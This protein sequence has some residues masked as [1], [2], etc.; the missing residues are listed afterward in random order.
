M[1][2]RVCL[3]VSMM[4]I[5]MPAMA[6]S[7]TAFDGTYAGVSNTAAGGGTQCIP[8][9]PVPRPL[10]IKNGAV[11]WASG[12]T[13]DIIFQG[14]VTAQ[15]ALTAKADNGLHVYGKIDATGKITAGSTG[16]AGCTITSI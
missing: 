15:G 6:Q 4:A 5:T 11:S 9:T 2:F 12:L 3:I 14:S 13:G 8:S 10:T 16:S 7:V 1:L